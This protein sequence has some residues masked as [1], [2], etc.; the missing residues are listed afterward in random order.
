MTNCFLSLSARLSMI[1]VS[2]NTFCTLVKLVVDV[3]N[4]HPRT[5][6]VDSVTGQPDGF[7]FVDP[8]VVRLFGSM[9][10]V[11]LPPPPPPRFASTVLSD[12]RGHHRGA[13]SRVGLIGRRHFALE[14]A[15]ARICREV[16]GRVLTSMFF[17]DMA[18]GV[19]VGDA[20]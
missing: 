2:T 12:V 15:A 10:F 19:P 8:D 4:T 20:R 6:S 7:F 18:F 11:I 13:R 9:F 17:R 1:P 14:C 5:S 3:H 16:G